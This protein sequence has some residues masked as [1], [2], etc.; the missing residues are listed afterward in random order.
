MF[1]KRTTAAPKWMHSLNAPLPRKKHNRL[2]LFSIIWSVLCAYKYWKCSFPSK[3]SSGDYGKDVQLRETAGELLVANAQIS[4]NESGNQFLSPGSF[5][6]I[7][8]GVPLWHS[9]RLRCGHNN[10]VFG[11]PSSVSSSLFAKYE[12]R[13]ASP[14]FVQGPLRA[15]QVLEATRAW[16][17]TCVPFPCIEHVSG[18]KA[19]DR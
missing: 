1:T 3:H 14:G 8:D 10:Y 6:G 13:L 12:F 9:V 17:D 11:C 19:V 7:I 2:H 15:V 16:K 4:C 18:R 5:W